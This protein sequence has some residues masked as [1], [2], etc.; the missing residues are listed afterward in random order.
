MKITSDLFTG[1]RKFKEGEHKEL[2]TLMSGTNDGNKSG[3]DGWVGPWLDWWTGIWIDGWTR[4]GRV[5]GQMGGTIC[6]RARV[7][8]ALLYKVSPA[9]N[10]LRISHRRL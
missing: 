8:F 1:A 4:C 3:R 6:T 7:C 9:I 2:S 10:P 5:H